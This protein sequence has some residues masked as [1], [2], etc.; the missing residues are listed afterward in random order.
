MGCLITPPFLQELILYKYIING[1]NMIS[2][3][4]STLVTLIKQPDENRLFGIDFSGKMEKSETITLVDSET[5]E[6]VGDAVILSS[7]ITDQTVFVLCS[8]GINTKKYKITIKIITSLNQI[9]EN[10]GY[11]EIIET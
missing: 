4:S 1:T 10:E 3:T 5:I 11:L 6:P 8:G 9:L 2:C 7:N